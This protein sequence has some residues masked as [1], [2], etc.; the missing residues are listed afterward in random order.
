MF[1]GHFW[2]FFGQF[3]GDYMLK[4]K[5]KQRCEK[6]SLGKAVGVCRLFSSIQSRYADKLQAN[7]EVKEIRCN[8]ALDGF[9]LG[10]YTSDFVCLK[11]DGSYMVREC[12]DRRHLAKPLTIRLLDAS[13]LYWLNKGI[14]DWGIVINSEV[15][16]G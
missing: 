10:D 15:S 1:L 12:V 4:A 11:V 5:I 2:E 16:N 8:Y 14:S 9:E 3:L 6:R 13:R 7:M